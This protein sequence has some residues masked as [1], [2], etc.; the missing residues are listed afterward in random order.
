MSITQHGLAA[1][2]EAALNDRQPNNADYIEK[3]SAK[4]AFLACLRAGVFWLT[5]SLA[6]SRT[7]VVVFLTDDRQSDAQGGMR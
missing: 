1:G 6:G 7:L 5:G 4:A 3:T 2:H